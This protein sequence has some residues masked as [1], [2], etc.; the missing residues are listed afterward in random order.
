MPKSQKPLG[1]RDQPTVRK[2]RIQHSKRVLRR[3]K[4]ARQMR[5]SIE[6][7]KARAAA[8]FRARFEEELQA[9]EEVP[10]QTLAL[11]LAGRSVMRA[12][13]E[14]I[15][16]D[17]AYCGQCVQRKQLG[18]ACVEVAR[19]EIYQELVDVR[20]SIDAAFG[21]EKARH[22]HGMSGKTRRKPGRLYPQLKGLVQ[23]LENPRLALPAPVRASARVDPEGWLKQL[24]PGYLR[25]TEMLEQQEQEERR[26]HQLREIRDFELE[27]FDA[28]YGEALA[29]VRSVF[30]LAG[31]SERETWHLLPNVQRRQLR[32]K[33]RQ[34][35]EA[36]AEG[37]RESKGQPDDEGEAGEPA[38]EPAPVA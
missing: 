12:I 17:N 32:S 35:R 1:L 11:E 3:I 37:L 23:A 38:R 14:L 20:R 25:L 26:E 8:G 31:L 15:R 29:F 13:D 5:G 36:R 16:A 7:A 2:G 28:V 34:E 10:D 21:R 18:E 27:S 4:A 19:W 6:Q 24:K 33:A 9:G 22:L 30:R